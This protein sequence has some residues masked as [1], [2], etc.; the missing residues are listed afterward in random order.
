[1]KRNVIILSVLA[2]AVSGIV[3]SYFF[4]RHFSPEVT[5]ASPNNSEQMHLVS[6]DPMQGPS[7]FTYAAENTV[8][9]VVHVK[10]MYT[11]DVNNSYS[12]NPL[13]DFFFGAPGQIQMQPEMASGSGVIIS[14]DGYIV[15][16]NHVIDR[17]S[18]IEV[19]LN[20]RRT[21]KAKVVGTDPSTD[22]ALLK[23]DAKNLPFLTFGNS[24]DLRLGQWVLAVGNPFN[25][26]STV[27][28][29]IVSAKARNLN[30]LAGQG[31]QNSIESFIQTDAAV[32]PGNSGGALVNTKGELVG[33]NTAIAS[34][35]G[36]YTGYSFA[37]PVSIV[38]KVVDDLKQYGAVQRAVLGVRIEELTQDYAD[39]NGI[40]DLKGVVIASVLD[41]GAAKAAGIKSGDVILS[42]NGTEVNS[43][44]ELQEQISTYHPK[45]EVDV[46]VSRDNKQ[47]HFKVVLRNRDG[48]TGVVKP[49]DMNTILGAKLQTASSDLLKKLG[50]RNG[51][52]IVS[53]SDGKFKQQGI[54]EGF[55]ITQIDRNAVYEP[56]DVGRI[57]SNTSGGVLI[58]GVY[59]NGIVA[60]YAIGM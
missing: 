9:A 39:K 21:F 6:L 37:I 8:H 45:E 53:L 58:E 24:D 10:T 57:L 51:V 35:T 4:S 33:I 28:A 23:I 30:L 55:I 27:T 29:G 50:I 60:Y 19:T 7:D 3:S 31:D 49:G 41:S 34:R 12:G 1:M 56:D 47:K 16:N 17:A 59:P 32:N 48:S 46:I 44:S 22:V 13:F 52:Q 5:F 40:K 26:T 38:K 20:D 25:L 54:K 36:T 11:R 18:S 14:S 15:T 43:P 42:V 2:A